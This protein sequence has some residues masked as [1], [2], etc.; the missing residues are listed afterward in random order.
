MSDEPTANQP[1][2]N[3]AWLAAAATTAVAVFF[4]MCLLS[5]Y[6]YHVHQS[7]QGSVE[8]ATNTFL[9]TL[10]TMMGILIAGTFIFTTF[11]IDGQAKLIAEAA[12]RPAAQAARDAERKALDAAARANEAEKKARLFLENAT[13]DDLITEEETRRVLD[14]HNR[15]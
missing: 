6:L 4:L 7:P 1:G 13:V 8:D 9:A 5:V 15:D 10:V 11:R 2:S 14:E 3:R 12:A